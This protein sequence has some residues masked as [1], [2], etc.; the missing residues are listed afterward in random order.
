M[1]EGPESLNDEA[2]ELW[3]AKALY[4]DEQ[5]GEGNEF[6]R[7]LIW[8]ATRRLLKVEPGQRILDACCGNGVTSRA[9]AALGAEV[10]A[11]D[12][13]ESFIERARARTTQHD[14]RIEYR[15]LDATSEEQLLALGEGEYDAIVC[16]M[17]LMDISDIEPI[18]RS[19][20]S[21]LRPDGKF[22]FSV[23]HPCFNSNAMTMS[24]ERDGRMQ[25][26][27]EIKLSDYL[28]V[29]PGKGAGMPGEPNPH[30]YF[31]RPLHELLGAFFAARLVLDGLEEPALQGDE[32]RPLSWWSLKGIPPVLVARMRP[33]RSGG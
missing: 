3:D 19:L 27:F 8:P 32:D 11:F 17:A 21:L 20:T 30:Y 18:S 12:F 7:A 14:E 26:K 16:N 29:P 24:A 31:H 28:S 2:R 33:A 25:T 6:Q 22:V 1:G 4:W 15:V 5:M 13:S 23:A 9:L 10:V